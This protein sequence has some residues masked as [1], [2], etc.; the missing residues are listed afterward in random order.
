MWRALGDPTRRAILDLLRGEPLT[1]GRISEHFAMT[2][3]GVRKHIAVLCEAGLVL[4]EERGR[5]R[6]HRVNPVPIRALYQRWIRPFEERAADHLLDIR[7]R[8]QERARKE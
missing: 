7:R 3:F 4:V 2:R 5:E 1:A 6:W 8:A